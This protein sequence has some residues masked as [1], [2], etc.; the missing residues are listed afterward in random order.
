[1]NTQ[2]GT[3]DFCS[4]AAA[5]AR[6]ALVE[7]QLAAL[8]EHEPVVRAFVCYDVDAAR[9]RLAQRNSGP[10]A[11]ALVGVKD[12]ICTADFPT[13]YGASD[14]GDVAP[15]RDAWCVS[16][17]RGRGGTVL[18]KTVCTQFAYP[19]PGPT[20]NP[21]D[22][23]RTPGGSSSGSAAAVAAGFVSF[24]LGTQTAAST[25][26]PA[27]YCGVTGYKP[28]H[29]LVHTDGVQAISTTLDHVGIFARS[30]RDAWYFV[31]ALV[32]RTAEVAAPRPPRR[33]L[34]LRLPPEIPH[35]DGYRERMAEL[36]ERLRREGVGVTALDLPF[37]LKDFTGL[38]RELCYW[39]AARILR[40]PKPV[41]PVPQLEALLA[42]YRDMDIARYLS[43]R[44]RRQA[45]QAEFAA[46]AAGCDA[47]LTPAA[48]GAAPGVGDT[49]DAVMSRFWTA[50][51]VPAMT[52]PMWSSAEGLPL[53]LQ[54]LGGLGTDRALAETAQWFFERRELA[55]RCSPRTQRSIADRR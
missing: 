15:R 44:V 41:R 48:T 26:R 11:G 39:E 25:I 10:L 36:T 45:Y 30:P 38:Q 43:A 37:A 55:S 51:Q 12:I 19:I 9:Q 33:L 27:S 14:P 20:T 32:L 53:G 29:G 5:E 1:M 22:A 4:A 49:G 6:D 52:V 35:D 31:S 23:G 7:R 8:A 17:T 3:P 46:L 24:A 50:L 34:V 40:M 16:E 54:L 21:H 28:T 42:P 13:R 47:V 18:G 2:T